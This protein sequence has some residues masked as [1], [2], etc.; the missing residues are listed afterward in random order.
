[1]WAPEAVWVQEPESDDEDEFAWALCAV[2]CCGGSEK[3]VIFD[4]VDAPKLLTA[5][6][7]T[8]P[9]RCNSEPLIEAPRPPRRHASSDSILFVWPPKSALRQPGVL[10][11][12]KKVSFS[13]MDEYFDARDR[14]VS[15]EVTW[16]DRPRRASAPPRLRSFRSFAANPRPPRA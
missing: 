12:K 1:M 15:L 9:Q 14:P 2:A 13:L 11:L 16:L 5:D 8:E 7:A 10:K 6:A 3:T 4:A